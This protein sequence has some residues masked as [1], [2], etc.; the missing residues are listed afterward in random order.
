MANFLKK[1][2][3]LVTV[4]IGLTL[5]ASYFCIQTYF[6]KSKVSEYQEKIKSAQTEIEN[7]NTKSNTYT[8]EE[9]EVK[10]LKTKISELKKESK[11]TITNEVQNFISKYDNAMD[12]NLSGY[13]Y[14]DKQSKIISQVSPFYTEEA[15]E[16][17]QYYKT[18]TLPEWFTTETNYEG[19]TVTMNNQ[20]FIFDE[21]RDIVRAYVKYI[22]SENSEVIIKV[23]EADE[24]NYKH[25][26]LK[27]IKQN[28]QW[29]IS[30]SESIEY[31]QI[32][33]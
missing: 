15:F 10:K 7:I 33:E 20:R 1:T 2:S 26:K 27:L 32:K 4:I 18:A 11:D 12:L 8:D 29:E 9:I 17:T 22:D 23:A 28:G 14:E 24:Q 5:I 19:K 25:E 21:Q 16:K 31:I 3:N 30:K 13:S 6:E